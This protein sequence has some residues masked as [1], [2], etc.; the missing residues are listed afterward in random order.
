MDRE[1]KE[2]ILDVRDYSKIIQNILDTKILPSD[3]DHIMF[4]LKKIENQAVNL[5]IKPLMK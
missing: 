2:F 4:M 5:V 1:L 3:Y